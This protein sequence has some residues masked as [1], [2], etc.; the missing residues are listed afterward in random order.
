MPTP[1]DPAEDGLTGTNDL[2]AEGFTWDAPDRSLLTNFTDW[3]EA[4]NRFERT[5]A[6]DP[7]PAM[8]CRLSD[9]RYVKVNTRRPRG[10]VS[11]AEDAG[12]S[13]LARPGA[14]K[15]TQMEMRR[16]IAEIPSVHQSSVKPGCSSS[17]GRK[18]YPRGRQC[19]YVQT[20]RLDAFHGQQTAIVGFA[21]IKP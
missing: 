2:W 10:R 7:T 15:A 17:T 4:E 5:R 20:H 19:L 6:A 18:Q 9:L 12:R 8:F 13:K 21:Q 3:F 11:A 16:L 14:W 1:H